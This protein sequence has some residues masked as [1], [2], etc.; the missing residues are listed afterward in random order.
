MNHNS[1]VSTFSSKTF[2]RLHFID[3]HHEKIFHLNKEQKQSG[4]WKPALIMV[5]N[6][7]FF[8]FFH[9]HLGCGFCIIPPPKCYVQW[10]DVNEKSKHLKVPGPG[11]FLIHHSSLQNDQTVNAYI[12]ISVWKLKQYSVK[13]LEMLLFCCLIMHAFMLSKWHYQN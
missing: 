11:V 9:H 6:R 4:V 12:C 1:L 3:W 2:S 7:F 13:Q 8:S 5:W 10:L